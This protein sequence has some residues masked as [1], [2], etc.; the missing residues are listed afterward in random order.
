MDVVLRSSNGNR[1]ESVVSRDA[2]EIRQEFGEFL[3]QYRIAA[4]FCREDA[5]HEVEDVGVRHDGAFFSRPS[6]TGLVVSLFTH[7]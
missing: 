6:G 7:R 5:M 2:P 4:L 3:R 1:L